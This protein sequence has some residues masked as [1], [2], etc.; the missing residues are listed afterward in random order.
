L[1]VPGRLGVTLEETRLFGKIKTLIPV[2]LDGSCCYTSA[3][4]ICVDIAREI[5]DPGGGGPLF[6]SADLPNHNENC[7]KPFI[8]AF[9]RLRN[10]KSAKRR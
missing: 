7:N 4:T 10:A 3:I 6:V 9:N 2:A 1:L 8:S 5:N